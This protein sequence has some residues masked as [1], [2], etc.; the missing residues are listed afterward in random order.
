[1]TST[2]VVQALWDARV[3]AIVRANE[4]QLAADAMDAA[5]RGGFR[6]CEF[7]LTTPG[8]LELIRDHARHPDRVVGAGTVLTLAQ[9]HAAVDAG[10]QFVVSPVTDPTIIAAA[11]EAGVAAMP[12]A[13]TPTELLQA[14]RAGAPLVKLFPVPANGPGFVRACRGPLPFV[15][16]VPTNGVD[17]GNLGAW[18]DAG[19]WA[20][21][22]VTTLFEP[23][24]LLGRRFDEIEARARSII[25]AARAIRRGAP[26]AI[27]DPFVGD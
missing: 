3:S 6:V 24:A 5:V 23:A 26:P 8:A 15:R 10:A 18:L 16:I 4:A 7:T 22:F 25:A 1:M 13:H 19:A 2:D 9:L 12:G 21:G 11:R 14:H 27:V 20:A 17:A